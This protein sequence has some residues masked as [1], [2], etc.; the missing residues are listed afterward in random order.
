MFVE[1]QAQGADGWF[2]TWARKHPGAFTVGLV[3]LTVAIT[4]GLLYKT[5]YAIVLYQGF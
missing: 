3:L 4:I 5:N 2:D 1:K